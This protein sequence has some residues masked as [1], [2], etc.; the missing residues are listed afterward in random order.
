LSIETPSRTQGANAGPKPEYRHEA[1]PDTLRLRHRRNRPLKRHLDVENPDRIDGEGV[2]YPAVG[3]N[4]PRNAVVCAA[5]EGA[6]GFDGAYLCLPEV[7]VRA[8]CI[9]E[10]CVIGD[11]EQH[12]RVGV[13]IAG[14]S[15]EDDLITDE[16]Q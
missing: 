4:Y 13:A 2:D 10:P 8:G 11:V 5:D 6:A 1:H 15:G 9:S 3:V 7:L 14:Y 12:I 16:G